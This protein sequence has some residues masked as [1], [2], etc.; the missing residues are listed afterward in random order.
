MTM[1]ETGATV[2]EGAAI[3]M[4]GAAAVDIEAFKVPRACLIA[5]ESVAGALDELVARV[6][7]E[8][9][10]G[11]APGDVR[12]VCANPEAALVLAR[13]LAAS[14]CAQVAVSSAREVALNVLADPA[15]QAAAGRR[16]K[17]GAPRVLLP[18]ECD[19][20][21]EDLKSWG[22]RPRR[23]RK[24]LDF[25]YRGFTE[26]ADD[27]PAW[28]FTVEEIAVRKLL[29]DDLRY[30][31]AVIEPEIANLA[32]KALRTDDALRRRVSA[33]H[34]L[35]AGYGN[36]SRASQLM[37]HLLAAERLTVAAVEG[38]C[39]EVYE[40]YP[41]EGGVREF[42]AI[43]PEAEQV[44]ATRTN[45]LS[46]DEFVWDDPAAELA[47]VADLVA[48]MVADGRDPAQIAVVCFDQTW[49]A[50]MARELAARGVPVCGLYQPLKLRGDFSDVRRSLA[51]RV[52]TAL[53]IV[54]DGRDSAAWRCWMG[55]DDELAYSGEFAKAREAGLAADKLFAD[56]LAGWDGYEAS[57]RF[58]DTCD[59]KTGFALL[60]YLTWA[61]T[62]DESAPVPTQLRA[63]TRLGADATAADMVRWLDRNQLAACY[64]PASGVTVCSLETLEGQSFECVVATGFVNG[65]VP[66]REYFDLSVVTVERQARMRE[67]DKRKMVHL[68]AAASRE[69]VVSA[70]ARTTLENAQKHGLKV[71]RVKYDDETGEQMALVSPSEL[72]EVLRG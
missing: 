68:R 49:Y 44:E 63:L 36:L 14:G 71:D 58:F 24:M 29:T 41:Y 65:A 20:V 64:E 61:M 30:L 21:F 32:C 66:S 19:I 1:A 50:R 18:Y 60:A 67:I 42:L 16:F 59:G 48:D 9:R 23:L 72:V 5:G 3:D 2:G 51:I 6:A 56:D 62:G 34:V 69:L 52:A 11:T 7:N 47:G 39:V 4:G 22:S 55:F 45:G 33:K 38:G 25:M 31:G 8:L 13:R 57:R 12:V 17:D 10:G 37:C 40:S 35:V 15:A 27:D 28:L 46:V 70:F 54:A 53:R 26:L 43:N